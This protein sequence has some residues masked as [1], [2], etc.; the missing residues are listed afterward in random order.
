MDGCQKMSSLCLVTRIPSKCPA[1]SQ[2]S[3]LVP[4]F[5]SLCSRLCAPTLHD[6]GEEWVYWERCDIVWSTDHRLGEGLELRAPGQSLRHVGARQPTPIRSPSSLQDQGAGEGR[7]LWHLYQHCVRGRVPCPGPPSQAS[8]NRC[9]YHSE[10]VT[11]TN[12]Q[13]S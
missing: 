9:S 1:R 6:H 3:C 13:A 4:A 7:P 2:V 11:V 5:F 12:T 10:Q 8:R